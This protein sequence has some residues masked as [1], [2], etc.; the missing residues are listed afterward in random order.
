MPL[1]CRIVAVAW[2][3]CT[4]CHS[5]TA[6]ALDIPPTLKILLNSK[7]FNRTV[8]VKVTSPALVAFVASIVVMDVSMKSVG[9]MY[10]S[11]PLS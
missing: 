6:Y 10:S 9:G 3:I 2:G 8:D 7:S 5:T 11:L 4:P 1:L